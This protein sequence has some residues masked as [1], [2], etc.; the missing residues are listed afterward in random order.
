MRSRSWRRSGDPGLRLVRVELAAAPA[1]RR[2]RAGPHRFLIGPLLALVDVFQLHAVAA[3]AYT[4]VLDMGVQALQREQAKGKF[5][6]LGIIE[7][8]P[9]DPERHALARPR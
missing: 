7:T 1:P 8:P 5:R 6:Y 2:A 3:T 9:A 4:H